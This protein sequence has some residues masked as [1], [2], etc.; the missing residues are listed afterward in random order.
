[1]KWQTQSVEPPHLSLSKQGFIPEAKIIMT[2]T[3]SLQVLL[4]SWGR[5]KCGNDEFVCLKLGGQ[6]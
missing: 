5:A 2:K 4:G 3:K 1:M 6:L